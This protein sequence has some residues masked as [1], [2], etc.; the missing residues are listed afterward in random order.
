[1][2]KTQK[3]FSIKSLLNVLLVTLLFSF[4]LLGSAQ[5]AQRMSVKVGLANI[6][7]EPRK[8][9]EIAWQVTKYHPFQVVKKKGNWYQCKDFEG[10]SGWIYK[11]LLSSTATV[12]T[13]KENC[14]VRSGPGSKNRI[15]FIVDREVPLKVLKRQG[16]WL[17][18][19]HEDGDKGWI[20]A[21]LVW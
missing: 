15:L 8:S 2:S 14:N 16:R 7:S 3:L 20:H 17:Q 19:M 9:A 11:T 4:V 12:I 18:I 1:M 5:A 21:S 13:I 6:R 10:D